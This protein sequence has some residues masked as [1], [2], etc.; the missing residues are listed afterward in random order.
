M[1]RSSSGVGQYGTANPI[2]V[3]DRIKNICP[4]VIFGGAARYQQRREA[5]LDFDL[6][7]YACRSTG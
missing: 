3:L 1:R 7:S 6:N 5:V 4:G 2:S